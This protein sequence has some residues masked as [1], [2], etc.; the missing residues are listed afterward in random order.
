MRGSSPGPSPKDH[1]DGAD[2]AP[3]GMISVSRDVVDRSNL[4]ELAVACNGCEGMAPDEPS[5]ALPICAPH[6]GRF[7]SD[8]R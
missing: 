5:P 6:P 8:S 3:L 7:V 2:Q 4:L 1:L